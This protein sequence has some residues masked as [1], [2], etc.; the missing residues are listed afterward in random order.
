MSPLEGG[1]TDSMNSNATLEPI[2]RVVSAKVAP[3]RV[4]L[5][6]DKCRALCEAVGLEYLD[7]YEARVVE[8]VIT[9]ETTDRYGDIIRAKGG[10]FDN[11]R[12]NPVIQ[13]A[14]NYA[15]TPVGKALKVWH[16]KA[17]NNVK[18]W[19]LYFD[20]RVDSTGRSDVIFK[21]IA[22]GGLPACS[23]GFLPLEE[24][25]R[26]K[27]QEERD[28]IGLG[29][30]GVE[31]RTWDLLEY[32]PCPVP[33]NPNALQNAWEKGGFVARDI[34]TVRD[35]AKMFKDIL[36]CDFVDSILLLAAPESAPAP[37]VTP[38]MLAAIADAPQPIGIFINN[39]DHDS[40]TLKVPSEKRPEPEEGESKEDFISRCIAQL[41]D[42]GKAPDQAAAICY[43]LWD[44]NK[45][46]DDEE[47]KAIERDML[48]A[49]KELTGNLKEL[50]VSVKE[51]KIVLEKTVTP[52]TDQ[53]GQAPA[54][55]PEPKGLYSAGDVAEEVF[56]SL[57]L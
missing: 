19:G 53:G 55:A 45:T 1:E 33:A 51:L 52:P 43:E 23:V 29:P 12:K 21:F 57:N 38:E 22:A 10:N 36:P 14:H 44:N 46:V 26:P 9:D 47:L 27:D 41:I 7:G 4:T 2:Q 13:F 56:G 3:R 8:H 15:D 28:A 49:M 34:G 31:Y 42:E 16:D 5:T 20:N 39:T 24:P 35:H 11:Y 54:P 50:G 18:A 30:Q 17:E 6:A 32:S 25:Y 40:P 37:A 48:A